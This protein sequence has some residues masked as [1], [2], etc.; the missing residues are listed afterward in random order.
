MQECLTDLVELRI[1]ILMMLDFEFAKE[2]VS[3]AKPDI[4][5]S[6]EGCA[7]EE[8]FNKGRMRLECCQMGMTMGSYSL[9]H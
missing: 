9:P 6:P 1:R 5:I 7:A 3:A 2:T 8:L 4:A